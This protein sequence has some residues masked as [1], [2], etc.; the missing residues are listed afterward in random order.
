M[1]EQLLERSEREPAYRPRP[2]GDFV[3]C[4]FERFVLALEKLMEVVELRPDHVPVKIARLHVQQEFI[5]QQCVE[6]V[7]HPR[8]RLRA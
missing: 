3:D 8:A 4:L 5:A 6:D 7:R 1:V 2:L